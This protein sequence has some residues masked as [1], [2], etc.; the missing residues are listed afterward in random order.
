[1][2]RWNEVLQPVDPTGACSTRTTW[3]FIDPGMSLRPS[4]VV[5][6]WGRWA[7]AGAAVNICKHSQAGAITLIL[8]LP[9]LVGLGWRW[10]RALVKF[11]APSAATGGRKLGGVGGWVGSVFSLNM[12]HANKPSSLRRGAQGFLQHPGNAAEN[13]HNSLLQ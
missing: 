10:L 5:G 11:P 2:G 12:S 13:G 1:M 4:R 6:P 8:G 3:A 9:G 7:L